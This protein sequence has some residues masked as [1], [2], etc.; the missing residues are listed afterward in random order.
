MCICVSEEEE[1]RREQKVWKKN[2]T[3]REHRGEYEISISELL[4]DV[5]FIVAIKFIINKNEIKL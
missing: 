3:D 2:F 5:L 1:G 4:S